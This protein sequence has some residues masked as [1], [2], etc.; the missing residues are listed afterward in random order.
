M[1]RRGNEPALVE[2]GGWS[3]RVFEEDLGRRTVRCWLGVVASKVD[4]G[5]L[6]AA[7]D[8]RVLYETSGL[9]SARPRVLSRMAPLARRRARVPCSSRGASIREARVHGGAMG[10]AE[11]ARQ[12]GAGTAL[13]RRR[14]HPCAFRNS[15]IAGNA[16][17]AVAP[18]EVEMLG[19]GEARL[20]ARPVRRDLLG[21]VP[22]VI[23]RGDVEDG[24]RP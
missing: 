1:T 15:R 24:S 14:D 8:V 12:R 18:L 19:G 20:E 17:D 11:A 13:S 21:R 7:S 16:E 5:L 6:T 9:G 4:P 2:G 10:D 23:G 22:L 3:L